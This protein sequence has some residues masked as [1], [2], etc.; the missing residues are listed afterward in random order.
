MPR[1]L[2]STWPA[3]VKELDG[4]MPGLPV[5]ATSWS[6]ERLRNGNWVMAINP[7]EKKREKEEQKGQHSKTP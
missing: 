1:P 4:M 2:A 7:R 3:W 5:D 6:I